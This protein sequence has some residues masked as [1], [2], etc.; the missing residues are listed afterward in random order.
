MTKTNIKKGLIVLTALGALYFGYSACNKNI[1][2]QT[3]PK[4]DTSVVAKSIIDSA[5]T[6]TQNIAKIK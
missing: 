4:A 5:K 3:E 2:T 1:E 6:V